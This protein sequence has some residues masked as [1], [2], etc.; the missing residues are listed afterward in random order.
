MPERLFKREAEVWPATLRSVERHGELPRGL[1]HSDVHLGN[2]YVTRAGAMGVNDWQCT[3]R[4]NW[5]R[6]F[7]YAMSTSLLPENR[8]AWEKDLLR[9]YLEAL[10]AAGGAKLALRGSVPA[11]PPAAVH[12][13]R[14]VDRHARPAAR[15]AGDAAAR[16][17][18]HV[19][20]PDRQAI[21]DLDAVDSF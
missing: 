18:A 2:W 10:R 21:D 11:L 16:D 6:D 13:A 9:L 17:L 14:L 4:G 15:S 8:R 1:I 5:S 19:H 3:C 20:R 12:G 7:A